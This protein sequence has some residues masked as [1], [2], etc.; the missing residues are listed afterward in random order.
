MK[1]FPPLLQVL[2]RRRWWLALAAILALSAGV[3]LLLTRRDAP[4]F[5]TGTVALADIE[6][7]V[8]ANGVLQPIRKVDVGAQVSGQLKLLHVKLGQHVKKGD[9]LAEIDPELARSDLD[10][11]LAELES[12]HAERRSI[13]ARRVEARQEWARQR[14]LYEAGITSQRELQKALAT[15]RQ[16]DADF[17]GVN[18]RLA[19][20]RYAIAQQRTRLAYTRIAAPIDGE[21]LSVDTREGQTVIAAQQAPT[22]LKLGD[23][24][25]IEV[26]AQVSEADIG[27]IQ[28]GMQASFTLLGTSEARYQGTVREIQPM[29]EKINN[30]M[31]FNVLFDVDNPDRRLRTDMTAQVTLIEREVR[32]VPAIPLAALGDALDRNWYRVLVPAPDG[33]TEVRKVQLGVIGRTHAQVLQGLRVGDTVVISPPE[34]APGAEAGS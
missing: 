22:I 17:A 23:L 30:A 7:S 5:L 20:G 25:R 9:L 4:A 18:A 31:F 28:P 26:R 21:V 16:L 14:S 6:R 24:S 32:Q 3:G 10:I 29:P 19:K 33:G 15:R 8:L 11:A 27:R 1:R 2:A 12:Q 13:E 34:A